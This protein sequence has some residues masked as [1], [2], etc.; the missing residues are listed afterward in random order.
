M[1][2]SVLLDAPAL[3]A[4]LD[5]A[6]PRHLT[7]ADYLR[8]FLEQGTPTYLSTLTLAQL[9]GTLQLDT[10]PV[11]KYLRLLAFNHA[12]A[13]LAARLVGQYEAAY[14]G[15]PV[16]ATALQVLA[17][18]STHQAAAL[19]TDDTL[20]PE[21]TFQALLGS[22]PPMRYLRIQQ[23]HEAAFGLTGKLF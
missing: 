23:P 22:R 7:A 15:Q 12:D 4:A 17:Q 18:A 19:L 2:S 13:V 5:R 16:P 14:P 9:A 1:I 20:L 11:L 8:Y 10:L 3:T 21:A 6:H